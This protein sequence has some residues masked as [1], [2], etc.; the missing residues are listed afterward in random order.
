MSQLAEQSAALGGDPVEQTDATEQTAP[1]EERFVETEAPDNAEQ[2]DT[3]LEDMYPDEG[4]RDERD[5]E[6][7]EEDP[8]VNDEAQAEPDGEEEGEP[9][10]EG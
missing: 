9:E 3:T 8:N 6:P 2:P 5:P 1:V 4:V 7:D 10:Q